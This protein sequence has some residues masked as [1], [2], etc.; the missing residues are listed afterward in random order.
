MLLAFTAFRGDKALPEPGI[1]SWGR[2][3]RLWQMHLRDPFSCDE[4]FLDECLA[5]KPIWPC[6]LSC[7]LQGRPLL[8]DRR[9]DLLDHVL[10]TLVIGST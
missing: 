10:C 6:K 5:Y 3:H 1:C 8:S 9:W 7:V 2:P 4:G